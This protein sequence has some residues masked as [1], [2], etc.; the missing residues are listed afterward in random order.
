M[1]Y[2][3]AVVLAIV[4]GATE[5]LPISSTGHLTLVEVFLRLTDDAAFNHAFI[6]L[7]QFPAILAV[8][9]YFWPDLWPFSEEAEKRRAIFGMWGK[10][11][12]ATFPAVALGPLAG[13][14]MERYLLRP[15]PIGAAL[16]LG[17]VALIVVERLRGAPRVMSVAELRLRTALFIGLF[18]CAALAPGT[19]RSGATIVGA[20]L[21][22]LARP[23]AAEFS[24]FL[25]IPTM[26]GAALY[27][28]YRNG[29]QFTAE[30]WS[31][32]GVGSAAS[33]AVSY[34]VVAWLM[35]YIRRHDFVVF[36]YY[37]IALA[38]VVFAF[39]YLGWL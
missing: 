12:V 3:K 18:Q 38:L 30:Q 21:L 23:A 34:L 1:V 7:I 14:Y 28:L 26:A 11:A 32:L 20:L 39:V 35:T 17:G 31:V 5:F 6:V 13:D 27:T 9:V 33:F 36:G 8:V 10:I 2:L 37:R 4:E 25:A 24:F 29:L 15:V 22:G 19:S 16:L